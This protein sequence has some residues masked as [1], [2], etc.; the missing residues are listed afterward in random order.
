M[1][2]C[3]S[4]SLYYANEYIPYRTAVSNAGHTGIGQP[5]RRVEDAR[6]L[7]GRGRFLDDVLLPRMCHG[8]LVMSPHAHARITRIDTSAA[9]AMPG[10]LAV[11]TGADVVA[12]G[13]GAFP[14]LY[15]GDERG[16]PSG[17]RTLRPLLVPDRVRFVGDRVAFV[18]AETVDQ[19]RDAAEQVVID[20]EPLTAVVRVDDALDGGAPQLWDEC[21]G[22]VSF[23][24]GFG[25]AAATDAA[26]AKAHATVAL[27][28]ENNRVSANPIEPRGAI[29]DHDASEDRYTL[30]ATSQAPHSARG[31][32]ARDVFR[33][34][35]SRLR[36]VSLDVGGGFGAKI[37]PYTEDALV[38]WAS[39]RCGRPVKWVATRSDSL[40]GDN[41]GRDQVVDGEMA[42]DARGKILGIRARGRHAIG[43]YVFHGAVTPVDY[44]MKLLP[45][46]Y[47]VQAVD[48][49]GRGVFTN[50]STTS[51]YRGAGRPEAAILVER[52]VDRAAR[53][54][55]LE[56]VELRRRNF[57]RS[58]AMPYATP[59]GLTYDTGEFERVMDRC[60]ALADWD[61][62]AARRTAS[63]SA[64]LLRG[65]AMAFY[66]EAGGRF[67]DR[68]ELRFDPTGGVTIFSGTHSHGQG[69]ATT[70]A[71]LVSEWLGLPIEAIQF[72]QGDT[73]VVSFGR[74]TYAARSSMVAAGGLRMA[75]DRI[76]EQA[77]PM[78][79]HLLE[80]AP[81]DLAFGDG[82]FTVS[83]TDRTIALAEV[84]R[85]CFRPRGLPAHL[86]TG[87]EASAMYSPDGQN[88]PNGCHACELTVDPETGVVKLERYT[89]VDDL[90]RVINPMICEGQ[91]HG[92]VAQGAGQ[93]LM[94]LVAY[95]PASGQLLSGS[96]SDYCMPRADDFPDIA[97]GFEEIPSTSNPLGVKGVG[98]AGAVPTPPAIIEAILDALRPLGVDDIS[99]P[100]TSQRVWE[101]IRAASAKASANAAASA[102][103]SRTS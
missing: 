15:I 93:A 89:V 80:A 45:N 16:G 78:A 54:L 69:H 18:V 9:A 10:V 84:A 39:K 82:A 33:I 1:F 30:Y 36:V 6:L 72:R 14:P 47:D 63:E 75:A 8:V 57:I 50:T 35:E 23:S 4:P 68:M 96:F 2:Y 83:G 43:A 51:A 22:N 76:I 98:E 102:S 44:S 32:L 13:V 24:I 81:Q 34:P 21:P 7:Q 38:L 66:I 67:N 86:G 64:G 90:G 61:G 53:K 28:V 70:Y 17:F 94:E 26:F 100:A 101:S 11:L 77:R 31:I 56:P 92:G 49:L 12:D 99:M 91:V 52:M 65:R 79:A 19:A 74:G 95:D 59:T 29:G 103:A 60:L 46:A 37:H 42:L 55:G 27:R 48:V 20:Y 87:L 85:A 97:T 88:H 58:S 5:V 25:D 62:F 71:Q 40:L 41:H 73:D 3:L